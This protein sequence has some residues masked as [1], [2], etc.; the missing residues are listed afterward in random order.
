[1]AD[2]PSWVSCFIEPILKQY[3]NNE[4]PH[5]LLFV[6]RDGDGLPLGIQTLVDRLLCSANDL[7]ACGECKTCLLNRSGSHPDFLAAGPEGKADII[8]VDAVRKIADCVF[9]TAQQGGNKVIWVQHADTMNSNSANAILKVLEEPTPNTYLLLSVSSLSRVLPTIRS[10][11]RLMTLPTPSF[12]Q[13]MGFLKG[14]NQ[15]RPELALS[16]T[17]GEVLTAAHV[18]EQTIQTWFENESIFLSNQSF[19]ECAKALMGRSF[20]DVLSQLLVWVDVG[21]QVNQGLNLKHQAVSKDMLNCL[22]TVAVIDLF[23]FR[24]SLLQWQSQLLNKSNLNQQLMV[25]QLV[26]QWQT[27]TT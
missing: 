21:I 18:S 4:L 17:Q 6:G 16:I 8:K 7:N 12:E 22:K 2:L 1:M 25:E 15:T 19:T 14:S 10:R 9:Q 23:R 3:Q 11:C 26:S 27:L 5:A 20:P 24:D 13:A